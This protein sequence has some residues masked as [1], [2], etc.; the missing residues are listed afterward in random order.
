VLCNIPRPAVEGDHPVILRPSLLGHGLLGLPSEID[1][2]WSRV[3]A[4]THGM[5]YCATDWLG[6]A[7][8]DLPNALVALVDL[9]H[10]PSVVDRTQ[11]GILDFLVLG[12]A[13]IA[14][15]GFSTSP[16]F[17]VA[18]RSVFDT[19]HLYYDG[20]SQ[21]G[22]FGGTV[23]AVEPDVDRAVLGVPGM[24]Y[25]LLL[26]RSK[27]FV[28]LPGHFG[29]ATPLEVAYPDPA[30][31]VLCLSLIQMLWDRADPDGYAARMTSNP[32]PDTP[33]HRVLLQASFGDHQVAN[34]ATDIEARTI[35]GGIVWPALQPG[36]SV[37]R[38]PYWGIPRIT[39]FPYAGS[40]LTMFDTGPVRVVK[41]ATEGA[42]PPP[43]F[44]VPNRA[45]IDPHGAARAAPCGQQQKSD[46]LQPGGLVTGP[47]GGPPY[48]AAGYTGP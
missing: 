23:V 16:A 41:R 10:F 38:I 20:N 27:D 4:A 33:A 14:P 28:P 19:R 31:R 36:R 40:A 13:M 17:R 48:Y 22:I 32:L 6:M 39:A 47:C 35:G 15:G 9:A 7:E 2:Q 46:F 1:A 45:G 37:D 43:A 34:I 18:G 30:V 21:G 11:Q 26:Y 29:Y 12:R 5:M 3:M 44:D 42:G 24:D 8:G 25:S